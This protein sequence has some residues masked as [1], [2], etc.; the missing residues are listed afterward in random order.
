[1]KFRLLEAEIL[2]YQ[3]RR[4]D[5]IA[6]LNTPDVPYPRVGDD[7]IKR[8][9]LCGLAHARLGQA[10]QADLELQQARRLSDASHSKLNGEVLRTEALVQIDRDH[11]TEAAQLFRESLTGRS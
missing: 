2:I 7:A 1:M 11:L 9:L 6:L 5:V 3:G 10:Q 8:N 4:P